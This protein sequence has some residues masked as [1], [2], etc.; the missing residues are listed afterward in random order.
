M[1]FPNFS[2]NFPPALLEPPVEGGETVM[3]VETS[4]GPKG[5]ACTPAN[6]VVS[7]RQ[8]YP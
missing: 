4:E 7:P 6:I 1:D 3:V 5:A 8:L 2:S